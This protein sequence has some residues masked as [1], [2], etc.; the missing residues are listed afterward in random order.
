L[1]KTVQEL[2]DGRAGPLSYVEFVE[3]TGYFEVKAERE[4]ESVDGR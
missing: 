3:W 4:K 1:H 2:V